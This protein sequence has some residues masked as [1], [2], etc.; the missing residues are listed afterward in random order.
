M[1]ETV[2][3]KEGMRYGRLT[4]VADLDNFAGYHKW[5]CRCDCGKIIAVQESHLKTGHTKSCGC[6]RDEIRRKNM[7]KM[8]HFVDG[9][10]IERITCKKLPSN[11]TTGHTGVCYIGKGKYRSYICFKNKKYSIGTYNSIEEA[12]EARKMKEEELF[13]N[14]LEEYYRTKGSK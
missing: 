5:K 13:G 4:V 10:C 9:T 12:V 1:Q 8:F 7:K 3:I 2:R 14:F 6:L 11:D